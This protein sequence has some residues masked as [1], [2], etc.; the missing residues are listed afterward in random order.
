MAHDV[1]GYRLDFTGRNTWRAEWRDRGE[2]RKVIPV[3]FEKDRVWYRKR[4][5]DEME[6]RLA[7]RR[8]FVV[9]LAEPKDD[10]VKP[11]SFKSFKGLYE[12]VATGE[13]V[14]DRGIETRIVRRIG[15][16]T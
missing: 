16:G 13:R 3:T 14:S 7:D 5:R 2:L 1:D 12:M 15:G 11:R 10:R 4:Y 8:P 9:A 6:A